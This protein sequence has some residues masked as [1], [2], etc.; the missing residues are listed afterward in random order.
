MKMDKDHRLYTPFT[1][2]Q[3][4]AVQH[5]AEVSATRSD[6][7]KRRWKDHEIV[8]TTVVRI[9]KSVDERIKAEVPKGERH[10]FMDNALLAAL[11][12]RLVATSV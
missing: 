8:P 5:E 4:I 7:A 9:S 11:D 6:A 3:G 10:A 1:H 2:A 12:A